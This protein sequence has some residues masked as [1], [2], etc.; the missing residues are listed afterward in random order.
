MYQEPIF[1]K[2]VFQERIWGGD[3][4]K[5]LFQYDIPSNQTG[6]AWVI[7]AHPNGPS[8]IVN[9]PLSGQTLADAWNNHH[10]LFNKDSNNN[11]A[12]PL[13]VKILDANDNL[14]VQ[15]HPDDTYAREVEKQPYGKTECWYVLQAEPEAELILGHYAKTKEELTKLMDE[16]KWDQLLRRIPVTAGDFVYVPS[17]T[18]HAIG[19]GIVLLE[20]QQSS[21]IT[22]RVYDYE[23]VDNNGNTRELHLDKA[24]Q[25]TNIPHQT[26]VIDQKLTQKEDLQMKLLVQEKY[27]TVYHWKIKGGVTQQLDVD[28]LQCSIISGTA[29]IEIDGKVYAL[30]KGD[31]FILPHSISTYRLIGDAEFIVSH[32]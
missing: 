10:E 13:L 25:V 1:L 22:Y 23:R 28:F 11:E 12:Y 6:E 8:E 16:G 17:G 29:E 20:T 5:P 9:G 21:D 7:S 18:I 4:L 3:K 26:P 31:N 14:S 30:K 27:F 19:R 32:T 15:V 24:K 2:P